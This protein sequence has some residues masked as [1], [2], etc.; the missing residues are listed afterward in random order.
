M[1]SEKLEYSV[2]KEVDIVNYVLDKFENVKN[3]TSKKKLVI[4]HTNNKF[5]L[6]AHSQEK[7]KVLGNIVANHKNKS[8]D[9][10]IK[11]YE[12]NLV[13]SLSNPP[14]TK[15]HINVLSHIFGHFS[16]DF[17]SVQ[18]KTFLNLIEQFRNGEVS[19]G[20]VLWKVDPLVYQ[21]NKTYLFSQTYFLLY[22]EKRLWMV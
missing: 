1:D 7:L 12:V 11:D 2:L 9:D 5:L 15:R 22:A 20:S 18:E 16:K 10:L 21:Y 6:M 4:F 17:D 19:L 3:D 14:T 8:L 13:Q